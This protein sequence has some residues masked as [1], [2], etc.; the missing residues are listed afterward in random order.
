MHAWGFGHEVIL[1]QPEP[2]SEFAPIFSDFVEVPEANQPRDEDE[3]W[4]AAYTPQQLVCQD[5]LFYQVFAACTS[6]A[7]HHKGVRLR[8][9]LLTLRDANIPLPALGGRA[10]P[11]Q[12]SGSLPALERYFQVTD[13]PEASD[14]VTVTLAFVTLTTGILEPALHAA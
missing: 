5:M 7:F 4:V 1:L 2:C 8:D 3:A 11:V 13:F 12:N 14:F 9:A 6:F 10:A